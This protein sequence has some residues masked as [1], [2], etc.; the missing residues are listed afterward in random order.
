MGGG[1]IASWLLQH[2]SLHEPVTLSN[3]YSAYLRTNYTSALNG[4]GSFTLQIKERRSIVWAS[5][6]DL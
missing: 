2:L 6:C 5:L 1:G 4:R 3:S